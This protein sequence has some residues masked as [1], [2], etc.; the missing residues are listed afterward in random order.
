MTPNMSSPATP[1][2]P[3]RTPPD[4][5]GPRPAEAAFLVGQAVYLRPFETEDLPLVRLWYNDPETRGL[6]GAALPMGR[7]A[8]E[9]WFA[10]MKQD[11]ERVW[12][13]IV[14]KASGKTVGEAGLLRMYYPWRT[15]DLTIIIG[16][17]EAR[18]RGLGSEAIHLLL[19]YAFG[20]LGFH[21]VSIGVV[22]WNDKAL[23]FY[24]R[25]GF[26]REGVRRD[27]YYW[28]HAFHDFVMMS[29]L[30]DEWRARHKETG[31]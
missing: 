14:E 2:S 7:A 11:K 28:N 19:D 31:K 23:R 20:Y 21:R 8:A 5:A 25:A 1:G 17:P 6:I 16:D 15:T 27:G 10:A 9:D 22:G 29:I 24:E 13:A 12:F 3:R 18:G 30:E 26:R 4:H